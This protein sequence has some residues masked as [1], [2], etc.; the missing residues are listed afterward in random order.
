[1]V[2]STGRKE[3]GVGSITM[4]LKPCVWICINIH[5][6]IYIYIHTYMYT[7]LIEK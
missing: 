4:L 5:K 7:H 3:G 1:M 2:G 6:Y